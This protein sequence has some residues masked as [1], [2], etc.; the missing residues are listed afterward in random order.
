M[1]LVLRISFFSFSNTNIEFMELG[2]LSLRSY[3]IVEVLFTISIVELIDKRKFVKVALNKN[4]E[5]FV[6]Y[7]T[8]LK[9]MQIHPSRI[10]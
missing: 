4:S 9:T 3:N 6:I 2:K 7:T 10:V 8:F 5:T 1:E